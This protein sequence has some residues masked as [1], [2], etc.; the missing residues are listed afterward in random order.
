MVLILSRRI[1]IIPVMNLIMLGGIPIRLIHACSS[2]L[3]TPLAM[4]YNQCLLEGVFPDKFKKAF[5]TPIPKKTS[6]TSPSD[7]RPISKTPIISK[8]FEDFILQW[9]LA[10]VEHKIDPMQFGFRRGHSTIHYL[11]R[12]LHDLLEHQEL[13][14]T[15]ADIIISDFVKAFNLLDHETVINEARALDVSQF[16]LCIIAS[17]LSGRQ[18]CVQPGNGEASNFQDITCGAAQGSRLGPILFVIVI[19]RLMRQHKQRYKFADDCSISLL[20]FLSQTHNQLEPLV[21]ELRGQADQLK[22]QLSLEKS[23][24]LRLNFPKK[25][26]IDESAPLQTKKS[27]K[28]LGITLSDDLRFGGHVNQ[29]TAKAAGLLKSFANLRMFGMTEQLLLSCYK[30]YT[31]S[32]V[33]LSC[34]APIAH[35]ERQKSAGNNSDKSTQNNFWIKLQNYEES[36]NELRHPTPDERRH[37]TLMKFGADILKSPTHRDILLQFTSVTHA[38]KTRMATF[39]EGKELLEYPTTHSMTRFLNSFVSYYVKHYNDNILKSK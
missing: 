5:I 17:F 30:T 22:L 33:R 38:Q 23:F 8:V 27:V 14:E 9:L 2:Y 16:L 10:E 21:A 19:N 28:I 7:L 26:R 18:Q 13:S 37:E 1:F 11:V 34:L 35:R 12:L 4:M 25:K 32:H 3:A 15:L 20:R 6:P 24:V 36:L 31:H 39:K 29:I